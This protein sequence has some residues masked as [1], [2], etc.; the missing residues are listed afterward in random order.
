MQ[1]SVNKSESKGAPQQLDKSGK[2]DKSLKQSDAQSCSPDQKALNE[3]KLTVDM[4]SEP[5]IQT[6]CSYKEFVLSLALL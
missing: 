1:K 5:D 3:S 4:L 2:L 6:R